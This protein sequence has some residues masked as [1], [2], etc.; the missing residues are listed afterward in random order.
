MNDFIK[1][2]EIMFEDAGSIDRVFSYDAQ[3]GQSGMQDDFSVAV[4]NLAK[5]YK[6]E[7]EAIYK[8]GKEELI[9]KHLAKMEDEILKELKKKE[10]FKDIIAPPLTSRLRALTGGYENVGEISTIK[11]DHHGR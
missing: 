5:G 9:R 6:K 1:K 11:G 10:Q 8:T 3:R 7:M 4:E 2:L